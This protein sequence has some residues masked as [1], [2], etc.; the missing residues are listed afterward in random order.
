MARITKPKQQRLYDIASRKD[1]Q[2]VYQTTRWQQL[3]KSKLFD[4][5][6][7]ELCSR[8]GVTTPAEDV[9]HIVSF[10]STEDQVQR[11]RLA[12]DRNNLQSLCRACHQYQHRQV[13]EEDTPWG[14]LSSVNKSKH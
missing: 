4:N 13:S 6:L 11:N 1:R 12:Y 9:H 3:R 2:K 5:P 7:C 10:M 8:H 14:K